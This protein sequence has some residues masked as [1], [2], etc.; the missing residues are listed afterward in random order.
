[1]R[2][3]LLVILSCATAALGLSWAV[4]LLTL[5]LAVAELAASWAFGATSTMYFAANDAILVL[6]VVG[7]TNLWAQSGMP[8]RDIAL[9]AGLLAIYDASVTWLLTQMDALLQRLVCRS[10]RSSRG[11]QVRAAHG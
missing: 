8:A 2:E 5:S 10:R 4:W 11:R 7:I 3:A 1:M 9:L 6:A